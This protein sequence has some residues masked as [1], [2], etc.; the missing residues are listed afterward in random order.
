V[1]RIRLKSEPKVRFRKDLTL[2][3]AENR[4]IQK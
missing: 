3:L 1:S 4:T 2:E